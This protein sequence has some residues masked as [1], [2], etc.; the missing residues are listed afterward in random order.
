VPLDPSSMVAG[1]TGLFSG[2]ALGAFPAA[3]KMADIYASYA[4]L[5]LFGVNKPIFTGAEKT[6]LANTLAAV[7]SLPAPNPAAWGT[8]WSSGLTAFWLAPPIIVT[9]PAQAG[10]VTAIP[11]ALSLI[12]VLAAQTAAPSNPPPVV[13][14]YL[15]N[16]LHVATLTTLATVA[17]PPST[18]VPLL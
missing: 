3:Q 17:P 7:F 5:G 14:A 10:L 12:G 8:A 15:A 16:A 13:A 2:P 9:G 1:F 6:M 4:A 11:G 18:I